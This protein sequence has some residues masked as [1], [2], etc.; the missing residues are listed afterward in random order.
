MAD[1]IGNPN[2]PTPNLFTPDF[3]QEPHVLVGRDDLVRSIRDGLSAGP[4]D[5]RFST[6]LLGP[7]GSGKTVVLNVIRDIAR[8]SGWIVLSLDASTSGIH[9][10][11]NEYISWAQET[12]ESIPDLSGADR[13]EQTSVKFRLLSFEWQREVVREVRPNWGLRRQLTTLADHAAQHETAVLLI[14]DEM[15]SGS[16][17][18]LRRLAADLQHITKGENLPLAFLGAGLSEMKHTL[19]EDNK[20]TFLQR[21]ERRDMPPLAPVDAARFLVRTVSDAGGAFEGSSLA[22]LAEASGTLPF[23]MQLVGHYAWLVA[24]APL[25]PIDDQAAAVAVR[26]A[27]RKAHER[28]SIPTWHS[29]NSTE[30]AV[31]R[32][33]ADLGGAAMPSQIAARVE[34]APTTLSRSEQHLAN[35]GCVRVNDDGSVEISDIIPVE[36]MRLL[37]EQESRYAPTAPNGTLPPQRRGAAR[38][39][40]NAPMPRAQARC[41]L[42]LGH[43]GGHRSQ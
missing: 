27:N 18:E 36:S 16:R 22:T 10:R 25:L 35:A 31:M 20:M 4:R 42:P 40:C 7:R 21:C 12:Y 28:I 38:L 14:L 30:Q 2:L 37:A 41:V 32:V 1:L 26:E 43:A 29:L 8:E 13:T 23:R 39:R 5:H 3:G 6:L 17:P 15:H 9:D 11:I 24:D 19:L 33:L 34:A